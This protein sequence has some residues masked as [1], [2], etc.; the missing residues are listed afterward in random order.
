MISIDPNSVAA[1]EYGLIRIYTIDLSPA[2]IDNFTIERGNHW[3]LQRALGAEVL[4]SGPTQSFNIADLGD[5]GLL[6]YLSEGYFIEP[7]DMDAYSAA[8]AEL[9]GAVV[10]IPS[11]AFEGV[12]QTLMQPTLLDGVPNPLRHLAT[13]REE[14][15][16]ATF[17]SL[18][19]FGAEGVLEDTP[20]RKKPSDAA[21]GGRV[22]TIALIVMGLLVWAMIKIAG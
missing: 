6:G 17:E 9:T 13:L 22:A 5:L 21:M 12:A 10:I 16:N 8:F 2:E 18:P 7:A 15:R 4:D 20:A 14:G 1:H 3:P 11:R 19:S